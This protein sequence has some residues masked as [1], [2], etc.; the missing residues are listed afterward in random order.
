MSVY[1]NIKQNNPKDCAKAAKGSHLKQHKNN[2]FGMSGKAQRLPQTVLSLV[3]MRIFL[4]G[5][6]LFW[7]LHLD[8]LTGYAFGS[9]SPPGL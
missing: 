9:H 6:C 3:C 5:V 2:L 1:N 7:I 4:D 8:G